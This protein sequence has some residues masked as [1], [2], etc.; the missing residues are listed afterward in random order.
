[1]LIP[2][3]SLTEN[4]QIAGNLCRADATGQFSPCNASTADPVLVAKAQKMKTPL[5]L[6]T[7]VR[8]LA[9]GVR[10]FPAPQVDPATVRVHANRD[11]MSGAVMEWMDTKG[12]SQRAYSE[13]FLNKTASQK[14]KRISAFRNQLAGIR[15]D[16]RNRLLNAQPGTP[17]HQS[18]TIVAIIAETGLRPGG[19][20]DSVAAGRFG[21]SDLLGS[22]VRIEGDVARLNFVGKAG[23]DN[24][25]EIRDPVTIGALQKLK[26][27]AGDGQL[28]S[29]SPD[30][31]R[32][33]LPKGMKLKDMRTIIATDTAEQALAAIPSPPPPLPADPEQAKK[34]IAKLI[35]QASKVVAGKLNNTPSVAKASY[36]HPEVLNEWVRNIGG[37]GLVV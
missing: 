23:K 8:M 10:K 35:L 16:A 33:V 15:K 7:R 26:D 12:S 14:W 5:D 34:L 17:E 3:S 1:M 19:R 13:A 2:I 18:A 9:L 27:S 36:I 37:A 24:Y 28:F 32:D 29:V 11:H 6:D 22:H 21:V 4:D 25:A 20:E 30:R 31:A